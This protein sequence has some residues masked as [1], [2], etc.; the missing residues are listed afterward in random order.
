MR[1]RRSSGHR[2]DRQQQ[3][4]KENGFR[5]KKSPEYLPDEQQQ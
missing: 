2:Q 1:G 3:A 5:F 4:E